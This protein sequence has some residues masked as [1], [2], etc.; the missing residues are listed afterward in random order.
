M[1]IPFYVSCIPQFLISALVAWER[2]HRQMKL[3]LLLSFLF[4]LRLAI[5]LTVFFSSLL[6]IRAVFIRSLIFYSLPVLPYSHEMSAAALGVH[7][8]IQYMHWHIH[9]CTLSGT[10]RR[11]ASHRNWQLFNCGCETTEDTFVSRTSRRCRDLWTLCQESLESLEYS[12]CDEMP[13][14][15][16]SVEISAAVRCN[17]VTATSEL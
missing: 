12:C 17:H 11:V 2:C 5:V 4:C 1:L 6:S 14:S 16:L 10:L 9:S 15:L 13:R 7:T 3:S 8:R